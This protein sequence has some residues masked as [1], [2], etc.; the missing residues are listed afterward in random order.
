MDCSVFDAGAET[1]VRELKRRFSAWMKFDNNRG[2][3][4][5]SVNLEESL[6]KASQEHEGTLTL[7][8]PSHDYPIPHHSTEGWA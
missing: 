6:E 1:S 4:W 3:D 8:E 5:D 7:K 2:V